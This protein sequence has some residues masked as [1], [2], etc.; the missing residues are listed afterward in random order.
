[1]RPRH[2]L[3]SKLLIDH[4]QLLRTALGH[5]AENV[6]LTGRTFRIPGLH[7]AAASTVLAEAQREATWTE[8]RGDSLNGFFFV[9]T[10]GNSVFF[11]G[12]S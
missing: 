3:G 1:M 12:K 5:Q 6:A 9:E 7:L 2:S 4:H 10:S 11:L 8:S